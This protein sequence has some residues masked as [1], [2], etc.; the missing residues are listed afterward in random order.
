MILFGLPAGFWSYKVAKLEEQ[1]DSIG[2]K[3]SWDYVE[4][5]DW[6]VI[7]TKI[8]GIMFII[9]GVLLIITGL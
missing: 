6:K 2:S 7:L 5:A 8:L 4:P 3:R 1:I 9:F